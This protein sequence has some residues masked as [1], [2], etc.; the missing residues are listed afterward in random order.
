MTCKDCIHYS[1]C[2]ITDEDFEKE[3]EEF[4]CDNFKEKSRFIELSCK[5]WDRFYAL[6]ITG[7]IKKRECCGIFIDPLEDSVDISV[8]LID[9]NGSRYCCNAT[10]EKDN[11]Q[12]FFTR[13]DAEKALKERSKK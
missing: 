10:L 6:Y 12:V 4:G 7:A 3:V 13:E 11:Y 2:F 8:I 1:V 9:E 5:V